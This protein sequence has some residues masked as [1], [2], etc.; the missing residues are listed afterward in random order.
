MKAND[1]FTGDLLGMIAE[2]LVQMMQKRRKGMK[3]DGQDKEFL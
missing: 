3:L 1:D 2:I